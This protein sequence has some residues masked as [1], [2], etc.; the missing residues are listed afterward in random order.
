MYAGRYYDSNNTGYYTDPASTS[1]MNQVRAYV[2]DFNGTGGDSNR[3]ISSYPYE[4]FQTDGGWSN[5]YPALRINYHVGIDF[6]ANPSYQGYRF[7]ND[8]NSNTVRFQINGG[9]S[10]TYKYTWMYTNTTGMYSGTN[11][12]HI[13][14]NEQTSYGSWNILGNRNSW[15]GLAFSQADSDPHL[16]FNQRGNG[17]GGLYWQGSGRWAIY[18]YHNDNCLG[19]ASSTTSST[20]ELYVSGDIYATGNIVAY[21]DRRRKRNIET[22]EGALD[23]VL[24]LRGVTYNKLVTPNDELK[25]EEIA[26]YL[27]EDGEKIKNTEI[28]VIAQEVEEVLPEVVTYAAD[29]DEYSVNYGNMAGLF[30]EAIKDQQSV[31]NRQ[32]EQI[33][34]LKSMVQTLMEK[35]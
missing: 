20:Y 3:A 7:M 6:G 26:D 15:Y 33:D 31:I 8:Y 24:Q 28:G 27:S 13:Y 25:Q 35:L 30:I 5:P 4:L 16:M 23:K 21:S 11:G 2:F 9:S 19:V 12:A 10:Y 22:I 29:V 34:E 14:P 1:N 18:Y 17:A 32:Q